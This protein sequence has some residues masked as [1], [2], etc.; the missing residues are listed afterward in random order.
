M[1]YR[2]WGDRAFEDRD[3]KNGEGRET[4]RPAPGY[5]PISL[6]LATQHGDSRD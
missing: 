6:L 5:R 1:A 3:E 4:A 2:D